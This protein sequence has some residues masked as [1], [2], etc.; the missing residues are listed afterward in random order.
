MFLI[1]FGLFGFSIGNECIEMS[2]NTHMFFLVHINIYK[3]LHLLY[4]MCYAGF[5]GFQLQYYIN[6]INYIKN[7]IPTKNCFN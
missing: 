4:C 5:L 7:C 6:I 3:D 1:Y 2:I